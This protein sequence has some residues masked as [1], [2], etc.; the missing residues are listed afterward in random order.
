MKT[1]C[2]SEE[3]KKYGFFTMSKSAVVLYQEKQRNEMLQ[4]YRGTVEYLLKDM[5]C[6]KIVWNSPPFVIS[7]EVCKNEKDGTDESDLH[8]TKEC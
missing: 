2:W 6:E 4:Q 5:S 1:M 8:F 3:K 7:S